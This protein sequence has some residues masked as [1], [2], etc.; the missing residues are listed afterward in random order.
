MK[1]SNILQ[2]LESVTNLVI[3][4][5]EAVREGRPADFPGFEA[6]IDTMCAALGRLPQ[7]TARTYRSPSHCLHRRARQAD[8]RVA[9]PAPG[10]ARRDFRPGR[11][12]A[13]DRRLR[14]HADRRE[15]LVVR[16]RRKSPPLPWGEGRGEA[17]CVGALSR[18]F[19]PPTGGQALTLPLRGTLSLPLT[20]PLRGALPLPPKGRSG[21]RVP[22]VRRQPLVE[23]TR[24]FEPSPQPSSRGERGTLMSRPRH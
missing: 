14:P 12:P 23:R 20:L 1:Q 2:E 21:E 9:D 5:R 17:T 24:R 16:T 7:E 15:A 4:S 6:R 13:R 18:V 10:D 22:S 19:A 8:D 11:T 3:A